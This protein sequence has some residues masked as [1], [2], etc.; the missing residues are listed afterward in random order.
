DRGYGITFDTNDDIYITGF[1]ADTVSF[2]AIDLT[3]VGSTDIFVGKLIASTNGTTEWMYSFGG[4]VL[5]ETGR[6]ILY[7]PD[8]GK[9]IIVGDFRETVDFDPTGGTNN[10]TSNGGEDVFI[11]NLGTDG[12]FN[13][14]G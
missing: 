1:F 2:D 3:S 4:S 5:S 6:Q 7:E 8:S 9:I 11:L 12:S 13:W 14:A 10:L